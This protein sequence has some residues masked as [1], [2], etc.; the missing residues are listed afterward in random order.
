[1]SAGVS[2]TWAVE[3]VEASPA[4]LHAADLAG[5]GGDHRRVRLCRPTSAAVVIGST[6]PEPEF[7]PARLP[8]VRRRSGGGAVLV[9]PGRLV[10]V[11]VV[12]PAGDPLWDDDV[13]RAS[14]WLGEVW[15]RVVGDGAAVHR[16]PLRSTPWSRQVCFAGLGP[17]EVTRAD[18]RKV[19]GLA[20]R[21]TRR[22]AAFHCAAL[23]AWDP[24]PLAAALGLPAPAA[25]D[26]A[27]VAAAL[28]GPIDHIEAEFLRELT[29]Y[30]PDR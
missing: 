21:R 25:A 28:P 14:W 24:A 7:E 6:Q 19:V 20:Q 16:G 18:G 17:G 23:L 30:S 12:V 5:A 26:L 8:V 4:Q 9:E 3:R 29:S 2:L 1:V 10:W 15:R 22:A 11:D 13:G 27:G